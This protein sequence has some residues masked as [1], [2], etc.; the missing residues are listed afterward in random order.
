MAQKDKSKKDNKSIEKDVIVEISSQQPEKKEVDSEVIVEIKSNN[1]TDKKKKEKTVSIKK[2][3]KLEKE[4]KEQQLTF[5]QTNDKYYRLAAEFE[6]FKK[7]TSKELT[8]IHK[9][10][11]EKVLKEILPIFDDIVRAV[12]NETEKD[13]DDNFGFSMIYKKFSKSL[14]DLNVEPMISVGKPFDPEL[15]H[16]LMVREEEGIDADMVIEE[17]EKGYMYK[18]KVLKHAKVVVSK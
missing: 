16:A 14:K 4:L 3:Q 8:T 15:H 2:Y 12:E 11:G 7:R 17:F 9:Y 10:A 1:K 6:N 18:D 13:Q 5:E